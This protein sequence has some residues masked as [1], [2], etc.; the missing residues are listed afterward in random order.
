MMR[1]EKSGERRPEC[2]RGA[3]SASY[4]RKAP[5]TAE[6]VPD[7]RFA[8]RHACTGEAAPGYSLHPPWLAIFTSSSSGSEKE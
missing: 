1:A 6:P 5:A 3:H 4:G 2:P 7:L 8:G